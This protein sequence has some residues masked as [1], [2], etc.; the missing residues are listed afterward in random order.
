MSLLPMCVQG[1]ALK[2]CNF[3]TF[4]WISVRL[5]TLSCAWYHIN[6]FPVGLHIYLHAMCPREPLAGVTKSDFYSLL[7][8]LMMASNIFIFNVHG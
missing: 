2:M 7:N 3:L 1:C 5:H 4:L 8:L 6:F